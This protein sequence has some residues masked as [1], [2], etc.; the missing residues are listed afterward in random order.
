MVD[1]KTLVQTYEAV[2]SVN[3][4]G[5]VLF[6]LMAKLVQVILIR[7][8]PFNFKG[9]M[10]YGAEIFVS[11]CIFCLDIICFTKTKLFTA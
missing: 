1:V 2:F 6:Q 8:H 5:T 10:I 7:E 11:R 4:K 9:G 3:V